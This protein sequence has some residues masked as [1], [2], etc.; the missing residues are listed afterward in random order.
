MATSTQNT[1]RP[2]AVRTSQNILRPPLDEAPRPPRPLRRPLFDEP[3]PDVLP[4]VLPDWRGSRS[5]SEGPTGISHSL[6]VWP[7]HSKNP[8][9]CAEIRALS[10]FNGC[11]H[12]WPGHEWGSIDG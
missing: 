12:V 3:E 7:W 8:A 6:S 11:A 10:D 2:R 4:D 1:P 5:S 9:H